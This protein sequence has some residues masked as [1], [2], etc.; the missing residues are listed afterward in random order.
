MRLNK[1]LD[2]RLLFVK[3]KWIVLPLL[4]IYGLGLFFWLINKISKHGYL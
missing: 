3:I 1:I 4:T 2:Y